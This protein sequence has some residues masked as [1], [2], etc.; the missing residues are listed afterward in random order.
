MNIQNIK[1]IIPDLTPVEVFVNYDGPKFYSCHDR[2]GQLYLAYWIDSKQDFTDWLYIRISAT[3]Y[4]EMKSG[5]LSPERAL[6][7][8]EDETA[9]LVRFGPDV[10]EV[11]D[12][13]AQA[14]DPDW[15][16]PADFFLPA[17]DTELSLA[18]LPAIQDARASFRNILDVAITQGIRK[19]E[20]SALALGRLL[21]AIQNTV[22]AL[23]PENSNETRK[24][25]ESVK[26]KN[27]LFATAAFASS[28]GVRLKSNEQMFSNESDAEVSLQRLLS[29]FQ[30]C[31]DP[32]SVSAGLQEYGILARSRFK[33]LIELLDDSQASIRLEWASPIGHGE[34]ARLS[35]QEIRATSAYLS[36]KHDVTT[37]KIE[38]YGTLVGVNV[39][40]NS[41]ALFADDELYKG[42]LAEDLKHSSFH[43]PSRVAA[44]LEATCD[45]DPLTDRTKWAYVL[46]SCKEET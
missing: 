37:A 12:L 20:I 33:H 13:M 38:K 40:K 24:V 17:I 36:F 23:S 31:S 15:L 18:P 16:P 1:S 44:T 7:E 11:T 43:V 46:L 30:L 41:F 5:R 19:Y 3:R 27:E 14:I 4:A 21:D 26:M 10:Y 8:P 25:A 6:K 39:Q 35:L 32:I 22:F 34:Q 28:F 45:I 9:H 29:L 42:T 2:A